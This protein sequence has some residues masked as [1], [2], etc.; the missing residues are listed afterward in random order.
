M[1][2][3][4]GLVVEV[5]EIQS[6]VQIR[7]PK[8]KKQIC[9][10]GLSNMQ[11]F[12]GCRSPC[13]LLNPRSRSELSLFASGTYASYEIILI[14]LVDVS[15]LKSDNSPQALRFKSGSFSQLDGRLRSIFQNAV[16]L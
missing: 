10:G 11:T 12:D 4:S 5:I 13:S 15:L 1:I 9:F 16:V 3:D 14:V 8:V 7:N 2:D 6:S